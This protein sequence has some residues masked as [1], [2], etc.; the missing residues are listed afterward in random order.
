LELTLISFKQLVITGGVSA[1]MSVDGS[2]TPKVFKYD[3]LR[4]TILH[5]LMLALI[6][7]GANSPTKFGAL[8]G[9]ANGVVLQVVKAQ[10]TLEIATIKDNGDLATH[11]ARSHFGSSAVLS[12][13]GISTAQGFMGSTNTFIGNI[14][15]ISNPATAIVL[16]VGDS[17]QAKVQDN[18][19]NIDFFRV[20]AELGTE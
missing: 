15:L 20:V 17:I 16:D 1:A 6:D 5:S 10:Q 8:A 11:C 3:I 13:L 12:I 14:P 4:P 9:L 7:E 18:L 19:S 2:S